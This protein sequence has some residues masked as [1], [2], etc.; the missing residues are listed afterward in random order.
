MVPGII[1]VFGDKEEEVAKLCKGYDEEVSRNIISSQ[2]CAI[3]E[4]FF[5]IDPFFRNFSNDRLE[6]PQPLNHSLRVSFLL[7]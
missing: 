4:A 6:K 7:R 2:S 1:R 5:G 3:F